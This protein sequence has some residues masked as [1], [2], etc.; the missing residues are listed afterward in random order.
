MVSKTKS[1]KAERP[2]KRLEKRQVPN[3]EPGQENRKRAKT[4]LSFA[5]AE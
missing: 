4:P 5:K 1:I 2:V 3:L